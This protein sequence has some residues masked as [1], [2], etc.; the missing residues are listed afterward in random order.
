MEADNVLEIVAKF[1]KSGLEPV[2]IGGVT[3]YEGQRSF[4]VQYMQNQG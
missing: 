2:Q 1:F 4:L 3:P